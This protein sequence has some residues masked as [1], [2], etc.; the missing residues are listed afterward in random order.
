MNRAERRRQKKIANKKAGGGLL[1]KALADFQAGKYDAAIK[2]CG[3]VLAAQPDNADAH[4]LTGVCAHRQGD[5]AAAERHIGEAVAAAPER[6]DYHNNLGHVYKDTRRPEE[7]LAAHESALACDPA[8]VESHCNLALILDAL[9]RHDEAAGYFESALALDPDHTAALTGYGNMLV[10]LKQFDRAISCL[11][12]VIEIVPGFAGGYVNLGNA[13]K[14]QGEPAAAIEIYGLAVDLAP[15]LVEAHSNMT[16][17]YGIL[18]RLDEALASIARTLRIDPDMAQAWHDLTN[19]LIVGKSLPEGICDRPQAAGNCALLELALAAEHG[20]PAAQDAF[21]GATAVLRTGS[22]KPACGIDGEWRDP[23]ALLHFGRSGSGLIHSLIDNHPQVSSPPSI[24]LKGY[25]ESGVWEELFAEGRQGLPERFVRM[26]AVLFDA[27]DP[28][29]VPGLMNEDNSSLGLKEG[30]TTVGRGHD[31]KLRV[32]RDVFCAAAHDMIG[33][34]DGVDAG[35]FFRIVFRAYEAA[36]GN[37][38]QNPLPFYHIHNPGWYG[39]VNFL[40]CFP[41]ARLMMMVREPV[42]SCESWIREDF[43]NNNYPAITGKIAAMLF[44]VDR[45]EFART[46]NLGVRLEDLKI[47]P[48]QTIAG[49]CRWL[50]IEETRSLYEMTAQG[51]MWWGDPTSADFD[52]EKPMP[53]FDRA[54]IERPVGMIFSERDRFVL[55]TLYYPFRVRFGYAGADPEGFARDLQAIRPMLD[56]LLDIERTLAERVGRDEEIFRRQS[57]CRL[58]RARMKNRWTL[59]DRRGDYPD[60]LTP[61]SLT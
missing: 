50:D 15:E 46:D 30:M 54:S 14:D 60:M 38:K 20:S 23:V 12:R 32:D 6:A 21:A 19:L 31:E 42:Q 61:L 1:Q 37:D 58:L 57:D 28:S 48:E 29:P 52:R 41:K 8:R 35:G 55:N 5:F 45:P 33:R 53:P 22:G 39:R 51:K 9:G 17:A 16:L 49:L 56:G 34:S 7:A 27:T 26:F 2:K 44:D 13:L 47:R 24:Y 43:K 4:H 25:F 3:T 10:N 11:R 40:R 59:L 18:G 36:L